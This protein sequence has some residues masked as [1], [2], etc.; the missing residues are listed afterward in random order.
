[1]KFEFYAINGDGTEQKNS[2]I[3]ETDAFKSVDE[4]MESVLGGLPFYQKRET[5]DSDWPDTVASRIGYSYDKVTAMRRSNEWHEAV[6]SFTEIE[7]ERKRLKA[8]QSG[9]VTQV[10][11]KSKTTVPVSI[12]LPEGFQLKS[13]STPGVEYLDSDDGVAKYTVTISVE[14]LKTTASATEIAKFTKYAWNEGVENTP[15]EFEKWRA[16]QTKA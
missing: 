10:N 3:L 14:E 4:I 7:G 13:D 8:A 15:E 16:T 12:K 2:T 6:D 11:G 1:M 5:P 9:Q